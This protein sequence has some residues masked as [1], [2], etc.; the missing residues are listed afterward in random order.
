[1]TCLVTKDTNICVV[2][3][4]YVGLPLAIAFAD[5]FNVVAFDINK[6]RIKELNDNFDRTFE[7][8]SDSLES[9]KNNITFTSTISDAKICNIFIITVPTPIDSKNE[10]NLD[11][12]INSSR[13]IGSIIKKDDLVIYE[14]TVYPGVT[15]EVCAPI[16]SNESGLI[17]NQDFFCGYSPERINPGDKENVLSNI[18]KVTSGSTPEIAQKVDFLYNQI[19]KAGTF[20]V[21]S[22]KVAEASKVIENTQRDVN[23]ALINELAI[24]FNKMK[25]DT[26]EVLDAASTKWNFI[27]LRPGLVGGH[28]ISID[29][30]YL[31]Y[32]S[33][34]LGYNPDLILTARKINNSMSSYIVSEAV[35]LMI[36]SNITVSNSNVLILGLTFKENCPDLRN[37]KVV[38]IISELKSLNCS[39]D[40][41]DPWINESFQSKWFNH[42]VITNPLENDSK[43]DLII[44]AVAHD[45]FKEYTRDDFKYLSKEKALTIDIK[46]IIPSAD[47]RL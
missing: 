7:I 2:G 13:L 31:T 22:I 23:I 25:I 19:I 27:D 15:E 16:I 42:K 8:E 47:W 3:L 41:Y 32:K 24:I 10:P 39:V 29:P 36:K 45:Q 12:L 28:C 26:H 18:V 14:S 40:V 6:L 5:K 17:F 44:L 30:Y 20:L 37:S 34:D 46:S 11:P 33:K 43:Y 38:D 21:G 1:M 9:V 4:G 35:K